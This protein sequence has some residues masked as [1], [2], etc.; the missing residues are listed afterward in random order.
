MGL[1]SKSKPP[2]IPTK[3]EHL[4]MCFLSEKVPTKKIVKSFGLIK[5]TTSEIC[6]SFQSEDRLLANELQNKAKEV[7]AN[8]IVNF[9][10]A[11]G[12]Y[13]RNG[14]GWVTSYLIAYGDAVLLEDE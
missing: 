12:S 13:Q 6:G 8:A 10:Y 3:T 1:F 14:A 4:P 2:V 9:R 7:G 5:A 11:T